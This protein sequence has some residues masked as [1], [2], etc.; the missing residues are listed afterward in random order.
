[1]NDCIGR[2]LPFNKKVFAKFGIIFIEILKRIDKINLYD[3]AYIK[4][5]LLK[6]KQIGILNLFLVFK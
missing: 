3:C 2:N 5:I 4:L 6:Y 1:M